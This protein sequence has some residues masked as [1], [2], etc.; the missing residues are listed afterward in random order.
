M[1]AA[2][3]VPVGRVSARTLCRPTAPAA[4]VPPAV[5]WHT[6]QGCRRVPEQARARVDGAAIAE[7][8]LAARAA[9]VLT[10]A[11]RRALDALTPH[12]QAVAR[13]DDAAKAAPDLAARAAAV[14]T[15]AARRAWDAGMPHRQA[16][17]LEDGVAIAAP[18]LA[19]R[20]AAVLT[21]AAPRAWDAL[22]TV[23]QAG[24]RL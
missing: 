8:D 4:F 23:H 20:A 17:A 5:A 10:T 13:E 3:A 22:L 16:R 18:D 24:A 12:R 15:T 2:Q 6:L 19:A 7:L 11:A 1:A 21:T 14:L 9:A